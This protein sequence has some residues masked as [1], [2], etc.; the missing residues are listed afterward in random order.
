MIYFE[1][2]LLSMFLG[3]AGWVITLTNLFLVCLSDSGFL[4]CLLGAAC[5]V[6]ALI[7]LCILG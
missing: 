7:F 5:F 6:M 3:D 2:Y 1:R 4:Y